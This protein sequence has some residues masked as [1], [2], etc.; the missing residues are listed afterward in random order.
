LRKEWLEESPE[1]AC[2][3]NPSCR[4]LLFIA[5]HVVKDKVLIL[6]KT[7]HERGIATYVYAAI[8]EENPSLQAQ[9]ESAIRIKI[10]G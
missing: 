2:P 5:D 10:L 8:Q 4:K 7:V 9:L 3:M 1:S 6:E